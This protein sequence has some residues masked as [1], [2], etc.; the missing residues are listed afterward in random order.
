MDIVIPYRA[1]R[2]DFE[3][4]FALRSLANVPHDRVIIA[5]DSARSA[6]PAVTQIRVRRA[7]PRYASSTNNIVA[8]AREATDQIIVT[9]DDTFIL[10]PWTF[11][12]EHRCTVEEYLHSSSCYGDYRQ[13]VESTLEI[14]RGDGVADPLF[15]GLHTPTVYERDKLLGLVRE[16][17]GREY[18]LRTL[19]HNI[20]PAP[21]VRRDD[22]KMH[23][24]GDPGDKDILSISDGVS[25][26]PS[27]RRWIEARFPDPSPYERNANGIHRH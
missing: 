1:T 4:R 26:N 13:H 22:V 19:Y 9:H 10:Q 17:R 16:Y 14:L 25:R 23:Q 2:G 21:S 18:L 11:R 7:Y 27:F 5:G 12:H 8:A 20:Y 6:S 3:L 24:W 15:F